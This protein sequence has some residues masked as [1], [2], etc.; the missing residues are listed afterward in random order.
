MPGNGWAVRLPEPHP[1]VMGNPAA[2]EIRNCNR[3]VRFMN[4]LSFYNG[5]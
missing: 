1:G 2:V 4:L 3:L 5:S